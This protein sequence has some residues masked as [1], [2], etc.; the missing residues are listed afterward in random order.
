VEPPSSA[1]LT[2]IWADA[3]PLASFIEQHCREST[4]A[5]DT[6]QARQRSSMEQLAVT[7][8]LQTDLAIARDKARAATIN[9]LVAGRIVAGNASQ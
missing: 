1:P 5:S 6:N 2:R 8:K 4:S 7:L 3:E 9:E